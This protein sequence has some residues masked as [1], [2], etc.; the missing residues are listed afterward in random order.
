MIQ[1]LIRIRAR[2]VVIFFQ[3][4]F[5][6][7]DFTSQ[8]GFRFLDFEIYLSVYVHCTQKTISQIAFYPELVIEK[9]LINKLVA[10]LLLRFERNKL[11][12]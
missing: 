7:N 3:T 10:W 4:N 5:S 6:G 8:R 2:I 12:R 11:S 9:I 1:S